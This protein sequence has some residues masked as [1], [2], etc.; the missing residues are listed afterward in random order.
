MNALLGVM[1]RCTPAG[2]HAPAGRTAQ[3]PCIRLTHLWT[4]VTRHASCVGGGATCPDKSC[5][6]ACPLDT[7]GMGRESLATVEQWLRPY[8]EGLARVGLARPSAVFS[9]VSFGI[10]VEACRQ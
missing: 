6:R 9:S 7:L 10:L 3:L 8:W 5:R 1:L 2:L 4:G